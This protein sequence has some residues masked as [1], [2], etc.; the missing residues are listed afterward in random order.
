M[1]FM[2]FHVIDVKCVNITKRPSQEIETKGVPLQ[3][4]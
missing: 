2:E 3:A 4:W 1:I